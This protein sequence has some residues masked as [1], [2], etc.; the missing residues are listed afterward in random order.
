MKISEKGLAFV[1]GHE[2]F[3]SKAYRDPVGIWTIGYGFTSRSKAVREHFGEVT[4]GKTITK[5]RARKVLR[6][7]VDEEFGKAVNRALPVL[8][9]HQFD[10]SSSTAFNVGPRVLKWK[11]AKALRRGRVADAARR[12]RTTATTAQGKRLRGLVRRREEEARLLQFGEYVSIGHV[13]FK[14]L[15]TVEAADDADRVSRDVLEH[16]QEKLMRLGFYDGDA[17]GLRGPLTTKAVRAFQKSEPDLKVDGVLS[18]ATMESIDRRIENSRSQTIGGGGLFSG[19]SAWAMSLLDNIPQWVVY[20]VAV[21][22]LAALV[23]L[24]IKYRRQFEIK[25]RVLLGV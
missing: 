23:Y 1:A 6:T 16:Y 12:L 4:P 5:A 18:R 17:D 21:L 10:A 14:P 3:V 7:V 24:V 20:A 22:A 19:L 13:A 2:G 15:D 11:W 9:Q 8:K 25:A